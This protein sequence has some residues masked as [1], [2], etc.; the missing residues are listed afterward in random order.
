MCWLLVFLRVWLCQ[1]ESLSSAPDQGSTASEASHG[2]YILATVWR[3]CLLVRGGPGW[4]CQDCD[5]F[6][7][8]NLVL[9]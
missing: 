5:N 8:N 6:W 3:T 4:S 1:E 7:S 2:Y 9:Q